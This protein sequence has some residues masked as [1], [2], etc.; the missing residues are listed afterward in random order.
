MW[1]KPVL[2]TDLRCCKPWPSQQWYLSSFLR[3]EL[4]PCGQDKPPVWMHKSNFWA[5]TTQQSTELGPSM[6]GSNALDG[7]ADFRHFRPHRNGNYYLCC[8]EIEM[9]VLR[10][11][12]EDQHWEETSLLLWAELTKL[13]WFSI[14]SIADYLRIFIPTQLW[15]KP[16]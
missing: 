5:V 6:R 1:L 13:P 4:R 14:I 11:N 15:N 3:P 9:R 16:G 7:F 8:T 2:N 12:E 10:W